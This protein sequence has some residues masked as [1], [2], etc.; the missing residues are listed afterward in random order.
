MSYNLEQLQVMLVEDNLNM[1]ALLRSLLHAF[2]IR[3]IRDAFNGEHAITEM[4]HYKPDILITDWVMEPV[5]GIAL[6][7]FIRA[8][9]RS[10]DVFMPIIMVTGHTQE[11]RVLQARDAGVTEFLAK[12]ISATALY[13]RIL[14][15]IEKPRPFVRTTTFFGPC[16]RRQNWSEYIGP[17]RR[18]AKVGRNQEVGRDMDL[19]DL[20][21]SL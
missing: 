7:R 5:D 4:S 18:T 2:G 13:H 15:V 19:E 9:D 6:S 17:D 14:S 10:P 16:R 3:G 11:W 8:D 12:P 20:L 21:Q 1:R